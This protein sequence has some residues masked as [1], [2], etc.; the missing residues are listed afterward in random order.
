MGSSELAAVQLRRRMY[1]K[2]FW[3]QAHLPYFLD[4]DRE[5]D[6]QF[7]R[8]KTGLAAAIILRD[9][10][11]AFVHFIQELN[12]YIEL[13]SYRFTKGDHIEL[14]RLMYQCLFEEY[15]DEDIIKICARTLTNLLRYRRLLN[16]MDLSLGWR[17]LY[18]L[19]VKSMQGKTPRIPSDEEGI[20]AIEAMIAACRYYFPL[21]A[22]REILD[23]ARPFIHPFDGSM[24]RAT[25]VMALFLP[26]RLT[27][28]E[29]DKYGAK[30]W[31]DEAWH[32]YTLSDNNNGF[33]E[34]ML[35]HLFSRLSSESCGYYNWT[36]KFDIIFSRVMRMFSLS[37]RK[38]QITV[39][40]S[41]NR[42]D[43]FSTWIVYMLGGKSDG[44]QGHLTQMLNSLEPY[45][46]PSN[47]GEHTERLLVFLVA[48]CNA[49]VSRL[50]KERYCRV[51]GHDIPP[52]MKL[53]DAQIDLFVESILPCAEWTIFAK[54]QNGLTPQIMRS[55]AFLSPGIVLPAILDV[56]YPSLSTVVEP[57]RLV[58]S[59]NCLVAVCVPLARDDVLGR[60][61]RPLSET[62]EKFLKLQEV[63]R[64]D[65]KDQA[66]IASLSATRK[67][68]KKVKARYA[69]RHKFDP[70]SQVPSIIGSP[71]DSK[72]IE[73]KA[74]FTR[75]LHQLQRR[76][77]VGVSGERIVQFPQLPTIPE[78]SKG[79][80]ESES[81]ESAE[82]GESGQSA[83]SASASVST[84]SSAPSANASAASA[85]AKKTVDAEPAP[86]LQCTKY[87]SSNT[88]PALIFDERA[89]FTAHSVSQNTLR[90][91]HMPNAVVRPLR[92][93]IISLLEALIP[94]LDVNDPG[95]TSVAFE[96]IQR[97]FS[98]IKI[99]DCSAAVEVRNDLS[100]EEIHLCE[101]TARIPDIVNSF[102]DKILSMVEMCAVSIPKSSSLPMGSLSDVEGILLNEEE[103]LL[104]KCTINA[105]NALLDNCSLPILTS[106][107]DKLYDFVTHN[108][109]DNVL[110]V[111]I[112]TGL[113]YQC[114]YSSPLYAF[115]KFLK[116]IMRELPP[117]ITEQTKTAL[118]LDVTTMWFVNL[119]SS[120]FV[121]PGEY[122][123]K[124]KDECLELYKILLS[125]RCR[126]AYLKVCESLPFVIG[127]L[128][129]TYVDEDVSK[130]EQLSLPLTDYLPIRFW[131]KNVTKHEVQLTWHIPSQDEIDLAKELVHLF[132]IKEI[133]K[134]C[135][136]QLIKKEG[137]IRSLAILESSFI[138]VSELLPPL[139]GE[140][141]KVVETD[142]P[143]KPLQY[144]TSVREI[145]PFT[146]DGRNIRQLMVECLHEIV[147]FLLVMQVD[148][149][150]PYMAICSLYSLIVF[151]N[152]STPAL[153]EQCLAQFVAM[154]EV[155]S[156]PL[157]GKKVN[158]Y[159][160]VRNCLSLLHR[161]RLVLAQTQRVSFN[162]SHLLVMKD[163]VRLATSP[164]EIVRRAAGVVLSSFFQTF[165]LSYV[166]LIED[167]LKFM[168]PAAKNV[169]EEDFK[170]AL[171]LLCTG[172]FFIERDWPT[173]NRILPELVKANYADKPDIIEMQKAIEVL[174]VAGWKWMPITVGVS[175]EL[176]NLAKD[177]WDISKATIKPEY[178]AISADRESKAI[179]KQTERSTR[180]EKLYDG[181][182]KTLVQLC[183]EPLHW[184]QLRLAGFLLNHM[185][186]RRTTPDAI[187]VF[188][189][190]LVDEQIEMREIAMKALPEWMKSS[191]PK[192]I[193]IEYKPEQ[194]PN[195]GAGSSFPKDYGLLKDNQR[196]AYNGMS[197]PG[198]ANAWDEELFIHKQY[199][200]FYQWGTKSMRCAPAS[201]QK[202]C[203]R[204]R[205]DLSVCERVI[206]DTFLDPSYFQKFIRFV[207]KEKRNANQ[208]DVNNVQFIYMLFRNYNDILLPIFKPIF[209]TMIAS[210]K[211]KDR[212]F[213]AELFAGLIR[214]S[215][216]WTF[217]KL[218]AMW[219]WI[220]PIISSAFEELA[221][222]SYQNWVE[223]LQ[224]IFSGTHLNRYPWLIETIFSVCLR[225]ITSPVQIEIRFSLLLAVSS[226]G[227]WRGTDIHNRALIIGQQFISMPYVSVREVVAKIFSNA[228][229]LDIKGFKTDKA[230]IH[231][232]F[233][234]ITVDLVISSFQ[235]CINIIWNETMTVNK[236][237]S[238]SI[239]ERD[240][241]KS[242][243]RQAKSYFK[244]LMQYL[245]W[246]FK[247][248]FAAVHRSV[249][250]LIPLL[251][252]F[253]NDTDDE[254]AL[255]CYQNLHVGLSNAVIDEKD[256]NFV[257]DIF[258]KT[259]LYSRSWK[260]KV[261][262]LKFCQV[263]VFS[264]LFV[265]GNY[266]RPLKVLNII[267]NLITHPQVEVRLAAAESIAGFI[268]CGY[269]SVDENF[270]DTYRQLA[271]D[272]DLDRKHGGALGLSAIVKG[273]PYT[274]PDFIPKL[275]FDICG[276]M[277]KRADKIVKES[278]K[279]LLREFRRTHQDNWD[280]HKKCFTFS[281]LKCINNLLVSPNYYV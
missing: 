25:R 78:A 244:A 233:H 75:F 167:V 165:Q 247:A 131:A 192:A 258:E 218:N 157:R 189:R 68:K 268:Q 143:M 254:V 190:M 208:F 130:R 5:A 95:K 127:N 243:T 172:Q 231:P 48:L 259:M 184:R 163:L 238:D 72:E 132:L 219:Q 56:V 85:E 168:D 82:S 104:K 116:Y 19:Y 152:A 239:S 162:K 146:L 273:F 1:Q 245:L 202:K 38:D 91:A 83:E 217:E 260:S 275:L 45:F 74:F 261:S 98:L 228:C 102:V 122:T 106:I 71:T 49:F 269:F 242:E 210:E 112:I 249:L 28:A 212:R 180:N 69:T 110:A 170:G 155:Y 253:E 278:L 195:R 271:D 105:F 100:M 47:T 149:T 61:R 144:R 161:Q 60:K 224:I 264:N 179:A 22:T 213:A 153:Y 255:L 207:V 10:R 119:A 237:F 65:A 262:L 6:D 33:W 113:I 225:P 272:S 21:E 40:V 103:M 250:R 279:E 17:P 120:L 101:E 30:L 178:A 133:E 206:V 196:L 176:V 191:K 193:K 4:L 234:H 70:P 44:A 181:L 26:T 7:S 142:V 200:G 96:S 20:S 89:A 107:V 94:A 241:R 171:Q 174:A 27:H 229:Y 187:R 175:K 76:L 111:S 256:A 41:G 39:G 115:P 92:S 277:T 81:G 141:I 188:L 52:W 129:C 197:M 194:L 134:L 267:N 214:G 108:I 266:E 62:V 280:E 227:S 123:I 136:P 173:L 8:I 221:P 23:E 169:T 34:I 276:I 97:L 151:C 140:P 281:Q 118:T 114:I 164:Y 232:R 222:D 35:L 160:V 109:F 177:F 57:H 37:V 90:L 18:D 63:A 79:S 46:H 99:V 36:D 77:G 13:Y 215:R 203:N 252:H 50:H 73:E 16:R 125:F 154:R 29:H 186:V 59:L 31:I 270:I 223:A 64:E 86:V 201:Q 257:M 66:I 32:W 199:V 14:V 15:F 12:K 51:E 148:D 54:G 117:L 135:K 198:N 216:Y 235:H 185:L 93:H 2:T 84:D 230:S 248:N 150:K 43:L 138:A 137:V 88:R 42:V 274:V 183:A 204:D 126:P 159:D 53:T 121:A 240:V 166:L 128:V 236:D 67:E 263:F 80:A 147:D 3:Q 9:I 220:G 211:V 124:F 11:P 251:A 226:S 139:C 182:M 246:N 265:F 209:Q 156:D 158:I 55:L 145:K 58:E 205:S 87:C 24:M